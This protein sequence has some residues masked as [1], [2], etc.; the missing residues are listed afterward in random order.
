MEDGRMEGWKDGRM[1][2]MDRGERVW[3]LHRVME[4]MERL[5]IKPA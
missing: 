2:G 4:L 1:D 5:S 3:E